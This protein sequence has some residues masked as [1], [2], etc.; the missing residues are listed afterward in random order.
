[1]KICMPSRV[2]TIMCSVIPSW[3]LQ[4]SSVRAFSS[5]VGHFLNKNRNC[6]SKGV[7]CWSCSLTLTLSTVS[8]P[9]TSSVTVS[10]VEEMTMHD[11]EE[12]QRE[13]EREATHLARCGQ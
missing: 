10:S 2:P 9:S 8:L 5:G 13:R 3:T 1:M 4:S 7:P 6:R 11:E 12:Q